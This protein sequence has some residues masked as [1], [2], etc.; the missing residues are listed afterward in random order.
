MPLLKVLRWS[1][2]FWLTLRARQ[3]GYLPL[4]LCDRLR[5]HTQ[6]PRPPRWLRHLVGDGDFEAVG[7]RFLYHC[8]DL[9][10]LQAGAAVLDIGCGVGR[11]ALPLTQHLGPEGSYRGF[12]LIRPAI[13][14]C[15]RTITPHF[16]NFRF[17]HADVHH[18]LYNAT[19]RDPGRGFTFPYPEGTFDLAVAFSV[20]THLLPEEVQ[21]YLGEIRRVLK[22]GGRSLVTFFL[23]N[24]ESLARMTAPGSRFHFAHEQGG[25]WTTKPGKPEA[26]LAYRESDVRDWVRQAGLGMGQTIY[27]GS[28][29]GRS[30]AR[31]GQDLLVLGKP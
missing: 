30:N 9:T 10:R 8:R 19:G 18:P 5:G 1:L 31:D 21:R 14:W 29:C 11:L 22:P 25:C 16:P 23:L 7:R 26:A 2:P 27:Y 17:D 15:R 28:W 13:R 6:P 20:F 12:D 24:E 3:L 4:E